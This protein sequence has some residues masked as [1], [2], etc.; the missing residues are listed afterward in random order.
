MSFLC[1]WMDGFGR[2]FCTGCIDVAGCMIGM[3]REWAYTRVKGGPL[4]CA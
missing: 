2:C 1:G 4:Y 3:D